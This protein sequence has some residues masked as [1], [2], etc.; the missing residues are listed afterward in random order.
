VGRSELGDTI[1]GEIEGGD[2]LLVNFFFD[3]AG[4]WSHGLKRAGDAGH[5]FDEKEGKPGGVGGEAR[6]LH[7]TL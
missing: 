4:E 3:D 5:V 2:A 1:T 7:V 6:G